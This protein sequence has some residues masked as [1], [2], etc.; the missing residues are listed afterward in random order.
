[1][2]GLWRMPYLLGHHGGRSP[3]GKLEGHVVV[4]WCVFT[5]E[6]AAQIL[7]LAEQFIEG[8]DHNVLQAVAEQLKGPE[9]IFAGWHRAGEN[10]CLYVMG[11]GFKRPIAL[12]DAGDLLLELASL[13]EHLAYRSGELARRS[14]DARPIRFLVEEL[15]PRCLDLY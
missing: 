6:K 11:L 7:Y 1:M 14:I 12:A 3:F 9:A 5:L 13:V 8:H 4:F 10:T 15:R 2:S